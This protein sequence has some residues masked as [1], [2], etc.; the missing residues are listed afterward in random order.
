MLLYSI[1]SHPDVF[2]CPNLVNCFKINHNIMVIDQWFS[3][4]TFCPSLNRLVNLM[5]LF[6]LLFNSLTFRNTPPANLFVRTFCV[7]T[8]DHPQGGGE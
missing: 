6:V 1:S 5:V 4:D 8:L 3:I 2:L 7:L